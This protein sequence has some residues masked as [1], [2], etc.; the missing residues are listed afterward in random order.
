M[1]TFDNP[2]TVPA[3]PAGRYSHVARIELG[4]RTMLVLSGQVAI[5]AE[6]RLVGENDMRAQSA[7]VLDTIEKILAAHGATLGDVVNIRT[8]L[9]DLDRIGEYAEV[10]GPRFGGAPPTSTTVEVSRLFVPG[11]LLEVEVTAIV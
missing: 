11:A 6:G 4:D 2:A 10:R 3:P 1:T 9:T 5:D 8:F 7:F